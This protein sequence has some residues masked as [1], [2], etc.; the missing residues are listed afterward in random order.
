MA[1]LLLAACAQEKVQLSS[2]DRRRMNFAIPAPLD[3]KTVDLNNPKAVAKALNIT[4]TGDSKQKLYDIIMTAP[5]SEG[6]IE[7]RTIPIR[8]D[9]IKQGSAIIYDA[10]GARYQPPAE[11]K[12]SPA[13]KK[14]AKVTKK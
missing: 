10:G 11:A 4:L 6:I 13:K 9:N 3:D 14:Q 12:K 8:V 1:L 2:E 5:S 7:R